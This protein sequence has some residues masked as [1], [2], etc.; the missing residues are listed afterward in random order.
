LQALPGRFDLVFA[1]RVPFDVAGAGGESAPDPQ[2]ADGREPGE[3]EDG[4]NRAVHLGPAALGAWLVFEDEA[5]FSLTPPTR[6]AWSRRGPTPVARNL[7][8]HLTAGM[9]RHI[10]ERDRLTVE[11]TPWIRW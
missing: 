7:N 11:A 3:A 4:G 9:G 8:A 2:H 6:R 5:G 1:V 10:A